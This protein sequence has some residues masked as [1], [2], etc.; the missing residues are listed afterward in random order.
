MT[1]RDY[2]G[3]ALWALAFMVAT[4]GLIRD[5][6]PSWMRVVDHALPGAREPQPPH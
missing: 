6:I 5:L 4:G 1:E 3:F 2:V